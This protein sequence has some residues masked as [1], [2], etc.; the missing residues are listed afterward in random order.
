MDPS[1][2]W[3]VGDYGIVG[4]LWAAP[5]RDL[6]AALD[7]RGLDTIDLATG[8]GVTA[9]ALARH[10]AASVVGVDITP[11]LLAEAAR[12][13]EA[14]S[15]RITWL[16]A[17]VTSV[18]LPGAS[19]DLV[20]S[21]FG[22]VFAAEPRRAVAEAVRLTR[23]GGQVVFTSWSPDGLFGEVRRTMAAH[24]PEAP[25]PWHESEAGIR[26][27]AGPLAAVTERHFELVVASPETFVAQ[28]EQWSAPIVLAAR[29]L[30]DRW[31]AA[32][33]QLVDVVTGTGAVVRDT[34]RVQV[35]YLVT[36]LRR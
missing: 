2:F 1:S 36:T 11:P 14:A 6:A 18:P 19:A 35:P 17:D 25:A 7:V 31:P 15:L 8:T 23:P 4:D 28:M 22:L 21:T 34:F 16:E 26:E 29:S 13:A 20:T 33:G 12:R 30:G 10:G 3:R 32:R 9:I 5:G 24:F 27:V